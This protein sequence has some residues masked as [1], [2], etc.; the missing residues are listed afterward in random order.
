MYTR[1]RKIL[2]WIW[3]IT[4]L[5]VSLAMVSVSLCVIVAVVSAPTIIDTTKTPDSTF[6]I[7]ITVAHVEDLWGYGFVLYYNTTILTATNYSSYDPFTLKH[8][9]V[10][11]DTEGLVSM[12][13]SRQ[14]D[15]REGISTVDPVPIANIEFT[16]DSVGVSNLT[17]KDPVSLTDPDA[18]WIPSD[19]FDGFFA[20]EAVEAPDVAV[21]EVT[22]SATTVS[23]GDTVTVSVTVE[24]Q[25][26]T[27]ATFNVS[28]Y[29]AYTLIDTQTDVTLSP[30]ENTTLTFT[31]DTTGV[32]EETYFIKA[33]ISPVPGEIETANNIGYTNSDVTVME[34]EEK[35]PNLL[36]YAGVA[37]AIVVVALIS[38][39]VLRA[40]KT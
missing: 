37:A 38:I 13:Y 40:R 5:L 32:A 12:S 27:D 30:G 8:P 3:P 19:V 2:A 31:W 20:N 25:G 10:I 26:D 22:A 34:E 35:G 15:E 11:N 17:F 16:V 1:R 21:T 33:E 9:S 7:D 14:M 24:N 36:V 18:G 39:Y 28:V 23:P 4:T 29:Y 6:S